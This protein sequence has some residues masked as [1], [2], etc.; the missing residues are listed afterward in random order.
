MA[1]VDA[2]NCSDHLL[3]S[4]LGR[5]DGR[6]YEAL[7]ECVKDEPMNASPTSPSVETHLR[8]LIHA[9]AGL[10]ARSVHPELRSKL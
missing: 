1:L 5:Y 2:F 9:V 4:A 10:E 6:V 8:P 3:N 7:A